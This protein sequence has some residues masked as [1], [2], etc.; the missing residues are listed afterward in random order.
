MATTTR[1]LWRNRDFRL[2][3]GGGLVNDFGD[4]VL[5]VALPIFVFVETGSGAATSVVLAIE[6]GVAVL[7]GSYGGSLVDR[8]NLRRTIIATNLLQ[9]VWLLPLLF[10]TSERIW[11]VYLVVGVQSLLRQLNNPATFALA[12]AIV[13]E[14]QL[15]QAN[16]ANS[17]VDSIARLIGSPVGGIAVAFGGLTAV[18]VIDLITFIAVAAAVWMV[19]PQA[20]KRPEGQNHEDVQPGAGAK[21]GLAEIQRRPDL[22]AFLLADT[23]AE[24]AFAMFPIVFVVIVI[25][26]LNGD[27]STIGLIR[28]FA[29]FGG[30]TASLVMTKYAT[31]FRPWKMMAWGLIGLGLVDITFANTVLATQAL[32]VFF[33]LF[34]LS[35]L[36]N[37]TAQIGANST[38]QTL[39]PPSILG[40]ISGVRS[41][42]AA[43]GAI[44]GTAIAGLLVDVVGSIT[45]FNLQGGF[46]I[47]AGIVT[48]LGIVRPQQTPPLIEA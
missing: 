33:A 18:V 11:P 36:P 48:Y 42:T 21:A 28:G 9:A 3:L 15:V 10:V 7:M 8:W 22:R 44:I 24:I 4:W 2:V 25:E 32:V 16:A 35:G 13:P 41:T 20:A 31:T 19:N 27:G 43:V 46:Y 12:P 26:E 45:L 14:S 29:A 1:S 5:V 47:A 6:L 38:L 17:F 40:R 39:T 30:I 23:I 37:I 34:A